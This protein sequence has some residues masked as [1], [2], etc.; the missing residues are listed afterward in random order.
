MSSASSP[1]PSTR[2][3]TGSPSASACGRP[4]A[5]TSTRRSPATSSA[6]TTTPRA[7][8]WRCRCS[9]ATSRS[10]PAPPPGR[11]RP[12]IVARLNEL[13]ECVVPIV[14]RHRGHID[15][16]IGDGVLA[17]FGAPE[18]DARSRRPRGP[19]RGRAR[20]YREQPPSRWLRGR[21]RRQHRAGG[22]GVDRRRRPALLQRDRRRGQ[23][24]LP[25]RGHHPR[26]RRPGAD[27]RRDPRPALRDDRGPGSRQA[28]DR[29]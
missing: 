10:S 13:W 8:R 14:A 3:S 20:P 16:F 19:V 1:R 4:S 23:P 21:D 17:V 5:P 27:H 11:A 24:L 25:G 18:P 15:Q 26:H 22:G 28:R 29:V 12:E 2:W 7:P 6:R 9:S